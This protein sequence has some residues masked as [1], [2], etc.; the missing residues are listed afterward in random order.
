MISQESAVFREAW[1]A[2]VESL[3]ESFCVALE[4]EDGRAKFHS[5]AW[6]RAGGGGGL[7][8]VISQGAVFEKGGVNRS[9]VFGQVTDAMRSQISG[10]GSHWFACGLSLVLHPLN[11]YVPSVH[12]NWRYFEL[13]NEE[14]QILDQWFG[15]GTD[16]TPSYL[17]DEDARHFHRTLKEAM[18]PW[19]EE[20]YRTYK[21]NCDAYFVNSHR[22]Q[23]MRGVGGI[24]YD[25]LRPENAET[26]RSL[27]SLQQAVAA[28]LMPAYLP[29]VQRRKT[30]SF[31]DAETSWQEI[32]RG[33]YVEFNLI[34]D[35]GTQFGLRTGGR[36][37]SILMS[38]PPRARW[39]YDQHPDPGT[40]EEAL[41]QACLNPR[42]W[43]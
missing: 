10:P 38:L 14:G 2:F 41:L 3:Q 6:K 13:T 20:R 9:A 35:R 19:G 7:T 11:P 26:V 15:G 5:D 16:L 32:R 33:R 30:L 12:A 18:Q 34:H 1:S 25:Y 4:K 27:F 21:K 22:N 29:I 42:E 40:P 23:E 36:T 43:V 24:F 17:F 28:A 31:G 37:E 8:R 39:A